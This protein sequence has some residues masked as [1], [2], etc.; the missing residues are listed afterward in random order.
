MGELLAFH[1]ARRDF[2]KVYDRVELGGVAVIQRRGSRPVVVADLE[3]EQ[4]RLAEL[5][6][7][8]PEVLRAD[9]GSVAVWLPEFGVYGQGANLIEAAEDLLDEI[10]Q[11]A[12][13]W[14]GQL[15]HA[16]NHALN[17]GWVR[18]VQLALGRNQLHDWVFAGQQSGTDS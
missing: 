6:P 14:E 9:D 3:E 11:Y 17:R 2:S 10:L 7:F 5:C 12:R 18:R 13:E 1:I 15:R 16:P 4:Q 8:H